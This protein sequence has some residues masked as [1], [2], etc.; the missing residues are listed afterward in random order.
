MEP[1]E[2]ELLDGLK[3]GEATHKKAL[4]RLPTAGDVIEAGQEAERAVHTAQGYVLLM[5][6]TLMAQHVLRR[7]IVSIGAHMGPLTMA[8]LKALSQADL[9]LLQQTAES[10]DG[11][12]TTA[13]EELAR[14]GRAAAPGGRA[15]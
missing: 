11:A 7:Q 12:V 13:L 3:V 9:Q 10:I 1:V 8:E 4:L 2:R 14:R 6:P 15:G 5:S